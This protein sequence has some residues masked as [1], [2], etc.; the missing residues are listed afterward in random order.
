MKIKLLFT[1]KTEES[2]L[3]EGIDIYTQRV[4]RY[5]PLEVKI[6]EEFAKKQ[7]SPA[8]RTKTRKTG[9]II[10]GIDKSSFLVLLDEKGKSFS[11]PEFAG[12]LE[13]KI[14]MGYKEIIF[15]TGGAYGFPEELYSRANRIISLSEMTFTHQ[16]VRLIL[17]EQLYRAMTIINGEPY[18]H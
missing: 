6:I 10:S 12:F 15:V 5:I 13:K 16:M 1:G 17:V 2:Y 8:R 7:G 11:S 4:K 14:I 9:R 18:H 3:K